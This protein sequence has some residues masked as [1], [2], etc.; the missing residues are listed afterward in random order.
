MTARRI[1]SLILRVGLGAVFIMASVPKILDPA[2]FSRNV[3]HYQILPGNVVNAVAILLPWIELFVG[4]FLIFGI[5]LRGAAFIAMVSLVVFLAAMGSAL[6]RGLNID[7]GC[8]KT[9]GSPLGPDRLIGDALLLIMA[10]L[11]YRWAS[12]RAL[13]SDHGEAGARPLAAPASN[14][15]G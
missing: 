15:P 4:L 10:I 6:A 1:L 13:R 12:P 9:S 8:F 11:V 14:Q 2:G 5:W 3:F 7:C